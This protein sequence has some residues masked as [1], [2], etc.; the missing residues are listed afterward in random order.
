LI[1]IAGSFKHKL[2]LSGSKI[3]SH[4]ECHGKAG[5][6]QYGGIKSKRF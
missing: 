3:D 4:R 2:F 1:L 6:L 5:D